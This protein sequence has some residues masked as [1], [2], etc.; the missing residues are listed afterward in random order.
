M[1]LTKTANYFGMCE[2][3]NNKTNTA[4]PDEIGIGKFW[5]VDYATQKR[6]IKKSGWYYRDIIKEKSE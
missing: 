1:K 5:A 6:T 4:N 2:M 3:N